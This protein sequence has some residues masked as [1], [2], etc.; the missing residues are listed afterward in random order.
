MNTNK[1]KNKKTS[2]GLTH[3]DFINGWAS[4]KGFKIKECL[5]EFGDI[6][7]TIVNLNTGS[8]V[9][10]NSLK[11]TTKIIDTTVFVLKNPY[12]IP[13]VSRTNKT[14]S[15]PLHVFEKAF[16]LAFR[17]NGGKKK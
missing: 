12:Y 8:H 14:N 15:A 6:Y 11:A 5:N 17:G 2:K 7:Y 9:H 13:Q 3:Y 10:A 1:N 4:Y 16:R